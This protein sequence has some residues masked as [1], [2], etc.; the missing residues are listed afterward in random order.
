VNLSPHSTEFKWGTFAELDADGD[1]RS[2]HVA[3]LFGREHVCVADCWC[4]PERDS[5]CVVLHN[6]M[7]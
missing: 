7:H 4:H 1:L 5:C 2:V 6:V 3:P